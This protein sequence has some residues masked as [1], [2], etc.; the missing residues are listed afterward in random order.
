MEALQEECYRLICS[1]FGHTPNEEQ[2][3]LI[4]HL[5]EFTFETENPSC[6]ILKGY[7]GTGKTSILGAYIQ[8]L[9]VLKRKAVLMA[10]TGRAAKS[11]PP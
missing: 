8:A 10:P 2:E 7:A 4:R 5:S 11:R 9:N 6:F 1:F 3:L